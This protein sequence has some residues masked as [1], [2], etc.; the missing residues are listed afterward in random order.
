[1]NLGSL[2]VLK[3]NIHMAVDHHRDSY[4]PDCDK[5]PA[6]ILKHCIE[7]LCLPLTILLYKSLSSGHFTDRWKV[8]SVT[9]ILK[10]GPNN[11]IANY[12]PKAKI[13]NID[14]LFERIVA[15]KLSFLVKTHISTSQHGFVAVRS[16][17]TNLAIFSN[18]CNHAFDM[19]SQIDAIYTDFA[20]A[21]DKVSHRQNWHAWV[22][23]RYY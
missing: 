5:F 17:S 21:F 7:V 18:Y 15:Y 4:T 3:E 10:S 6:Y 19:R 13:I 16:T 23:L 14:E 22:Y 8:A 2:T 9:P 12:K 11:F 20:K 1:L